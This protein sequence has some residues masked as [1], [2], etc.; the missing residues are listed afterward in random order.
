MHRPLLLLVSCLSL[1]SGF[2]AGGQELVNFQQTARAVVSP[3]VKGT[4]VTFRLDASYASYVTVQGSWQQPGSDPIPMFKDRSGLW[5]VTLTGLMQDMHDYHFEVDGVPVQDPSNPRVHRDGE[6][7]VNTLMIEGPRTKNY[8]PISRRGTVSYVWYNSPLLGGF[9]RMAVYLP[10]GY[11]QSAKKEYPVLY[12]LHG[13]GQ[14]EESWLNAGQLATV[15]DNLIQSGRAVPM[16]VVMPNC[17]AYQQATPSVGAP[18]SKKILGANSF[19]SSL[20]NEIIPF[21]EKSYKVSK[22][23]SMRGVAGIDVGGTQL[24]NAVTLHPDLFDYIVMLGS[25]VKDYKSLQTD[26]LRVKRAKFKLIWQG[27]GSFDSRAYDDVRFLHDALETV[28]MDN[29]LYISNGGHEWRNW[30]FY[31]NNFAPIL[32]KY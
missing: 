22:K 3:E 29:T 6:I 12:L 20:V 25:G 30:R 17:N 14:D 10:Y 19:S 13:E 26:L 9:R 8:H 31:L 11:V 5:E 28:D 21:V 1:I 24:F 15:M 27:C 16:I 7:M 2:S 4:E 18:Q 23:K 32:F